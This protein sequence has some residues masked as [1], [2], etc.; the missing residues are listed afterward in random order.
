MFFFLLAQFSSCI[1]HQRQQKSPSRPFVAII[2]SGG[3]RSTNRK[4]AYALDIYDAMRYGFSLSY[5][6]P[7]IGGGSGGSSGTTYENIRYYLVFFLFIYVVGVF[8]SPFVFVFSVCRGP[9]IVCR[10]FFLLST[11]LYIHI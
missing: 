3:L 10:L 8:I 11:T 1:L 9:S 7:A 4:T 6:K 5:N 2:H